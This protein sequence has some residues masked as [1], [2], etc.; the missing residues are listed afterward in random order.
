MMKQDRKGIARALWG[1][2]IL[3]VLIAGSA[4]AGNA[5]QPTAGQSAVE[6]TAVDTIFGRPGTAQPGGVYRFSFPRS[7]L[8]VMVGDVAI[9]SA[10]ALGSWVAFVQMP[11]GAKHGGRRAG[12]GQVMAMGDL[13]LTEDELHRVITA[14]QAGGIEQTAVHHHVLHESPRIFYMHIGATGDRVTLARAIR[15]AL[16]KSATPLAASAPP[17]AS[18]APFDMDTAAV[19]TALGH[20][21]KVNGG[22]YQ[23]SVPRR[24][25]IH[26]GGMVLPPAMGLATAINFQPTGGGNAAITGDFVLTASEV[27]PVIRALTSHGIT[28]TALHNHMLTETPRLFF[29]HFWANAKAPE[30]ARGLRAALDQTQSRRTP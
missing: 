27:N 18:A 3:V 26:D 28:V 5:Q 14:L 6:W 4:T 21:G 30:L 24:H 1:G 20:A 19:R 12:A 10:L 8:R 23:V 9:K 25:E 15:A 13:V 17:A 7:D 29:M 2:V 11:A 16:D 22:V